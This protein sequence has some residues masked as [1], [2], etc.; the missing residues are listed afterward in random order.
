MCERSRLTRKFWHQHHHEDVGASNGSRAAGAAAESVPRDS[1]QLEAA[2]LVRRSLQSILLRALL[3]PTMMTL[4]RDP[5]AASA[6]GDGNQSPSSAVEDLLKKPEPGPEETNQA[7]RRRSARRSHHRHRHSSERQHD[8]LLPDAGGADVTTNVENVT[9]QA[10]KAPSG[11]TSSNEALSTAPPPMPENVEPMPACGR[12]LGG[13]RRPCCVVAF[14]CSCAFLQGLI[15]NGCINSNL[16]TLERRYQLRSVETGLIG[17][18][19]S[20]AS[21]MVLLPVTYFGK[22]KNKPLMMAFGTCLMGVGSLTMALPYF[23]GPPYSFSQPRPDTCELGTGVANESVPEC[24]PGAG[25]LRQYKWFFWIGNFINGIGT[26]PYFTL[27]IAY[28]DENFRRSVSSKY[29]AAFQASAVVGPATGFVVNGHFLKYYVDQG[30]NPALLGL[31]RDS[32][33]WIGA[34]WLCF[35]YAGLMCFAVALPVSFLPAELPDHAVVMAEKKLEDQDKPV[36]QTEGNLRETVL[37]LLSIKPFVLV[38][39]AGSAE[40][41]VASGLSSFLVKMLQAQFS[42][43]ASTASMIMGS[44][45]IPTAMVGVMLGG[46]VISR[47]QLTAAGIVRL[48]VLVLLVPIVLVA[49]LLFHCDNIPYRNVQYNVGVT[50]VSSVNVTLKESCN[51][52]CGCTTTRFNP[53]CGR[54]GYTYYSPCYAGCLREY[55]TASSRAY[56]QCLC[57]NRTVSA[58]ARTGD[59]ASS[60]V[61]GASPFGTVPG[62]TVEIDAVRNKCPN[63]CGL[64]NVFI[65]ILAA[66]VFA[67]FFLSTPAVAAI[68]RCIPEKHKSVGLGIQWIIVRAFGLIPAGAAF[69]H[70]ID[71]S[72]VLWEAPCGSSQGACA[73]YDNLLLNRNVYFLILAL[74]VASFCCFGAALF[75]L[76]EPAPPP[77]SVAALP[78]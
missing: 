4:W 52:R 32:T 8:E 26:A 78:D 29:I 12:L 25:D 71:A 16:A 55:A 33:A 68:L 14:F 18:L 73:I 36:S 39:F 50:S 61:G 64:V 74:K 70:T 34:W 63:P 42:M 6:T 3:Q 2:A 46:V 75:F 17:S 49:V 24:D 53:I 47:F 76:R 43:T 23:V 10:A 15:T 59:R 48:C 37:A 11:L 57:V 35:L 54:D 1:E 51:S 22:D 7:K 77:V 21:L 60:S 28:L 56:S 13:M 66:I 5:N 30:V 40:L 67:T 65:P 27:G 44:V 45:T 19:Y 69:G 9:M 41:M 58:R 38:C 31:T 20:V 72:C 62:T